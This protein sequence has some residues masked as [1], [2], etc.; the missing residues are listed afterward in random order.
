MIGALIVSSV[1]KKQG[2]DLPM[3]Y[4]PLGVSGLSV[5]EICLGTMTWGQQNSE[6]EA[7]A[8]MDMAVER[9][10]NFFDAAEMYPVP[11]RAETQG[12]TERYIG[13]WFKKTGRRADIVMATKIIGPEASNSWV[14]GGKTRFDRAN[15]IAAVDDNL[16][17]LQTDYIDLYQLHWPDRR[18]NFFGRLGF[19]YDPAEQATPIEETLRAL[20][21][22][23]K[24]GKVRFIGLSN[25]TAWGAM[26]FLR[27]AE[28]HGLPRVQSIQNPYNLLNRSYEIGLAEVSIREQCGLLAYS[29]LAMGVLSGKFEGGRV[30]PPE[31]R[32]AL[33][34]RFQRYQKP[35]GWKASERYVEIARRHGFDPAQMA[36][37]FVTRQPFVT[38]NIIGATSL[39]Q[40]KSN[41]DSAGLVLPAEVLAEIEAVHREIPNPCP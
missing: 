41:I 3:K 14:R 1:R 30:F 31:T 13:S 19:E 36:L 23:V 28:R 20:E 35:L 39:E 32:L 37:A 2:C 33:F 16:R 34:E 29:P 4:R 5:S 26:S 6:A 12:L 9:G 25:E 17:R 18:A 40:L 27:E 15:I 11:P 24:A 21:E 10:I 38:A 8:Q 22:V 7:H